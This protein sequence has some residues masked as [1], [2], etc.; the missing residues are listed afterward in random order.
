MNLNW[1]KRIAANWNPNSLV[2]QWDEMPNMTL[3][4]GQVYIYPPPQGEQHPRADH[5]EGNHA[6]VEQV[7]RERA[8]GR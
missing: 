5:A 4:P 1:S 6:L 7:G 8:G 2:S 3:P